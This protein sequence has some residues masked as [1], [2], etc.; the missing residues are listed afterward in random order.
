MKKDNK[1][2]RILLSKST[3][4]SFAA[5]GIDISIKPLTPED[6]ARMRMMH[7]SLAAGIPDKNRDPEKYEAYLKQVT[8]IM[9]LPPE[10]QDVIAAKA[11]ASVTSPLSWINLTD[12]GNYNW[13]TQCVHDN[14]IRIAVILEMPE[15]K[16]LRCDK[17]N[18]GDSLFWKKAVEKLILLRDSGDFTVILHT[19]N[20]A[21]I[22]N[23]LLRPD[24]YFVW[25]SET[26]KAVPFHRLTDKELRKEHNLEKMYRAGAFCTKN[27]YGD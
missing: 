18:F 9:Q 22:S 17:V 26:E 6:H 16:T 27:V 4:G 2:E 10:E 24:C 20:T 14:K 13:N 7:H 23:D 19:H 11:M 5:C 8:Q 1:S 25:D 12:V 15:D 3:A 21:L